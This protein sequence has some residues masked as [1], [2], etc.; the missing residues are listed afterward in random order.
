ML[1]RDVMTAKIEDIPV[2]ATLKQAAEKMKQLNIGALPV[3]E[4]NRLVGMIT[5]RDIAMRAIAEG[6]DPQRMPVGEV[7]S[8]E[9]FFCYED[10]SVESVA[11]LMEEKQIRRLPVFDRSKRAIGIVSLGDLAVRNH[12]DRLTGKVLA[13]VCN[14]S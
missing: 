9:L 11:K 2:D 3:R 7:M 1:L 14:P 6:R 10:E 12:D 5:D 8:R 13:R 4:N